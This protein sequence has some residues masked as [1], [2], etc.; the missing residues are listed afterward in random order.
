MNEDGQA[1]PPTA[2]ADRPDAPGRE[3]VDAIAYLHA[4]AVLECARAGRPYRIERSDR[5]EAFYVKVFRPE[6]GG[7]YWRGVRV[8]SHLPV[9]ECSRDSAQI[10]VPRQAP[11]PDDLAAAEEELKR[12][13]RTGG[14]VVADPDEVREALFAA[15]RELRDGSERPGPAGTRWRWD[16]RRLRWKLTAVDGAPAATL[17]RP[18][19]RRLARFAP[20]DAPDVHLGPRE[21]SAIRARLNARARW[22]W[23][24]ERGL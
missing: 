13:I 8:A 2:P 4:V 22:A 10:H 21:Q 7:S 19:R 23:E 18:L 24:E 14:A 20:P 12:Q 6:P 15:F 5:S 1:E 3:P 16:E 17:D 9:Y 11:A